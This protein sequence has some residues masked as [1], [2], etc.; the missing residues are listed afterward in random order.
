MRKPR[1]AVVV[2]ALALTSA[3]ANRTDGEST[4]DTDDRGAESSSTSSS[5][6][7]A[8]SC[9]EVYSPETLARRAFAFDGIVMSIEMRA[10]PKLP[11][12]Q[13]ELPWVTFEVNEWYLGGSDPTVG[14]WMDGLNVDTSAGTSTAEIGTRL[15]VAGEPRWGGEPLEDP[16]AWICGFTQPWS[17]T[18]AAEWKSATAS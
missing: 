7:T 5:T 18:A 16:L 11:E 10:D 9:V 2:L 3:C 15:L 13:S 6:S 17:E 14:I 1:V 8:A 4:S 12:G